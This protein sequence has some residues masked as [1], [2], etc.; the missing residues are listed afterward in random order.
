MHL[1]QVWQD[2]QKLRGDVDG[3][4]GEQPGDGLL[5]A[6]LGQAALVADELR[7]GRDEGGQRERGQGRGGACGR[8]M[9]ITESSGTNFYLRISV[10]SQPWWFSQAP[11]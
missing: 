6:G 11:G 3:L 5:A 10:C 8:G 1:H 4:V 7:G 2:V 9:E